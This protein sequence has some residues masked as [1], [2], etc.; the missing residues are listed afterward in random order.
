M[1]A[2]K[3]FKQYSIPI[4]YL[5]PKLKKIKLIITYNGSGMLCVNL[6]LHFKYKIG[7]DLS[8]YHYSRVFDIC[9]IKQSSSKF[10]EHIFL[11][12]PQPLFRNSRTLGQLLSWK[13]VH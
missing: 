5:L 7:L 2:T 9:S 10:L 13:S 11:L 4:Q 12:V 3:K 8:F 6:F 1:S